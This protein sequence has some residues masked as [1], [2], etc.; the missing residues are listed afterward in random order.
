GEYGGGTVMVWDVGTYDIIEG[1]YWKGDLKLWLTGK[2]LKGEWHLFRIKSDDEKPVWLIQ[3]THESAKAISAK[4]ESTSVLSGRTM[5]EIAEAKDAVWHNKGEA[6]EKGQPQQPPAKSKP[7]KLPPE[8]AFVEP[9][10]AKEVAELPDDGS[11]VYEIKLDGYRAL[12]IK[13]G[14]TTRIISRNEKNLGADFPQVVAALASVKATSALLDGEIVAL[15]GNGKPSFQLLQNRKSH[16]SAIVYYAFDLLSLDGED[17][18]KRPLEERKTKLAEIVAGSDVRLSASFDGPADR[19]VAG[20]EEMELEGVIAKKRGSVYKSGERS[21]AWVKYKLSPEQ[22]FVVGGYKRGS[23]LESLVVGYFEA[24]KLLCAGKVRQGLNPRNRRELHAAFQPLIADVCPFANL[25]NS[26]K[27]HWGEGITAE[28]MKE[29]QWIMP[30]VV[31]QVSFTEWTSGGNLRH[32]TFKGIRTDKAA[33]H[34]V[35]ER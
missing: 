29:I 14:E 6:S 1:N 25:P 32:G 4:Q 12:G 26:K 31:A 20:V 8:P 7:P 27:S 35:R 30:R 9:M 22:E 11:W 34:V 15:D 16:G 24:G 17:W 33:S 19:V 18:R 5:E 10:T 28:Q 2:K 21:G 23:P 3:K 13:H